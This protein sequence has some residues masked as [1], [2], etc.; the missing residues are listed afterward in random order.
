MVQSAPN[1]LN[2]RPF[3]TFQKPA[4]VRDVFKCLAN[5]GIFKLLEERAGHAQM[6][7]CNVFV[8]FQHSRDAIIAPEDLFGFPG[9]V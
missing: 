4:D 7:F 6:Q 8:T 9:L 5:I 2:G 1:E 3:K